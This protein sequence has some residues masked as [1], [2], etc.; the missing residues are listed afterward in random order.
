MG[1]GCIKQVL[2]S[3]DIDESV[4]GVRK[5]CNKYGGSIYKEDFKVSPFK[6]S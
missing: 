5:M 6:K 2:T 1:N 4:E 3:V